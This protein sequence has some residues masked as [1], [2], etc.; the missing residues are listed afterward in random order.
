M[1]RRLFLVPFFA[2]I[3]VSIL[4]AQPA[5][6]TATVSL[7][8]RC[9]LRDPYRPSGRNKGSPGKGLSSSPSIQRQARL[10]AFA[11]FKARAIKRSMALRLK[12][13]RNGAS[14][15]EAFRKLKCRLSSPTAPNRRHPSRSRGSKRFVLVARFSWTYCR[16]DGHSTPPEASLMTPIRAE[17]TGKRSIAERKPMPRLTRQ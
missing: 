15:P 7:P 16:S 11:C 5:S 12:H 9:I 3:S 1:T 14:S 13:I 6:P 2:V 17:T 4:H 10:A 8:K